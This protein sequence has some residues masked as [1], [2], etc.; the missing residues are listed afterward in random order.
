MGSMVAS[1]PAILSS[2]P[3]RN[4]ADWLAP[5]AQKSSPPPSSL[6]SS[7]LLSPV[8]RLDHNLERLGRIER[9]VVDKVVL[10]DKAQRMGFALEE[11][12][13]QNDQKEQGLWEGK[14]SIKAIARSKGVSPPTLGQRIKGRKSKAESAIDCRALSR[15]EESIVVDYIRHLFDMGSPARYG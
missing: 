6:N 12:T 3:T 5:P 9:S 10:P 15:E 13:R 11:Y 4:I 14:V 2:S 7:P 8:A 1:D